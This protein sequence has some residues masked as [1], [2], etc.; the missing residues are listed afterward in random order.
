MP[1]FKKQ[2]WEV[3][4]ERRLNPNPNPPGSLP[5]LTE[6]EIKVA[7]RRS[8]KRILKAFSLTNTN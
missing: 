8:A 2:P 3:C 6:E 4:V 1:A 7:A 5:K